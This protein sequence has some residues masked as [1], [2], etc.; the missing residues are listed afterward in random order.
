VLRRQG[1]V[2]EALSLCEGAQQTVEL[3][4]RDDALYY[5]E[6]VKLYR[7]I[8]VLHSKLAEELENG[9]DRDEHL[10]RAAEYFE[11]C[12]GA[13]SPLEAEL[14]REGRVEAMLLAFARARHYELR[15]EFGRSFEEA[16]KAL[17]CALKSNETDYVAKVRMFLVHMA[18][19][20]KDED[21][22]SSRLGELMPVR[23]WKAGPLARYYERWIT[24]HKDKIAQI[25]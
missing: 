14:P 13:L 18:I 9:Q 11:K 19:V 6:R 3:C 21:E 7:Y 22:A 5:L 1:R 10:T 25:M 4:E 23:E 16:K 20:L 15:A 12:E 2:K 8:G 17:D 24:G